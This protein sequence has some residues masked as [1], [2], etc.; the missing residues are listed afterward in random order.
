MGS[1]LKNVT[2]LPLPRT[3]GRP[4]CDTWYRSF[5][6][7]VSQP[8]FYPANVP[9]HPDISHLDPP[10]AGWERRTIQ[11]PRSGMSGYSNSVY[12]EN[13]C[14]RHF[15]FPG[16]LSLSDTRNSP[17]PFP[18]TIKKQTQIIIDDQVSWTVI[19]LQCKISSTGYSQILSEC[20]THSRYLKR[21]DIPKSYQSAWHIPNI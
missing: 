4:L 21:Q 11:L 1:F 6:P 9:P 13:I 12:P 20:L 2:W 14:S 18:L 17:N 7:D 5:H 3:R 8:S 10:S 19:H 16:Q 15:R